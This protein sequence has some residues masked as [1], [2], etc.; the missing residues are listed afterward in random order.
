MVCR[1]AAYSVH[2]VAIK[3][4]SLLSLLCQFKLFFQFIDLHSQPACMLPKMPNILYLFC[5]YFNVQYYGPIVFLVYSIFY[6]N[7]VFVVFFQY[8]M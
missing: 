5:C 8:Y 1:I 3:T 4:S 2:Y 6:F 7:I